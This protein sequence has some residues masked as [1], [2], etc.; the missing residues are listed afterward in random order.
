MQISSSS[1]SLL[2]S[3]LSSHFIQNFYLLPNRPLFSLPGEKVDG[4]ITRLDP[5]DDDED[6]SNQPEP[7]VYLPGSHQLQEGQV[8][9]PDQSAYEMLHRLNVRW[10]CLSFDILQDHLGSDRNTFPH[11]AFFCAGTNAGQGHAKENEFMIMKAS[12]MWGTNKD[13]GESFLRGE[14]ERVGRIFGK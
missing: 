9:E 8:L 11:E 1:P 13:G 2:F 14:V 12:S 10:P 6:E 4:K 5:D 7:Q 3:N